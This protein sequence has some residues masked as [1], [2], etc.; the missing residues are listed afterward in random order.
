MM[1]RHLLR[2]ER[3]GSGYLFD[4]ETGKV[5]HVAPELLAAERMRGDVDFLPLRADA[6]RFA[7]SVPFCIWFELTLRCNLQ[8][9]HCS[10]DANTRADGRELGAAEVVPLLKQFADFGIFEVR[11]SG[12]EP[13][14]HREFPEIV[15]E[16]RRLGLFVST[17]TNGAWGES[18]R[19]R[20]ARLPVGLWIVSLDGRP[21]D[22]NALRPPGNTWAETVKTIRGL[23]EA[24]RRVRV[25]TVLCRTNHL[26]LREHVK[27]LVDL[28]VE[29]LTLVPVRPSGRAAD[30]ERFASLC[31]SSD[32]YQEVLGEVRALREE[33]AFEIAASYDLL[34]RGKMFN[35]PAHFAKRC[36]AGAEAA[37]VG[38]TGQLRACILLD[39]DKYVVGDLVRGS[40]D[41]TRLWADDASW[42]VF[43]DPASVPES[44]RDCRHLGV[45]C[46]GVCHV[47]RESALAPDL[48]FCPLKTR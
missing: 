19:R 29:A 21:R 16:A 46:F 9:V 8:C 28:G 14:C 26:G 30:P 15:E 24:G 17:S 1:E 48:P 27:T 31:L 41:L 33:Y 18:R 20:L 42:G 45:D 23:V 10:V 3:G 6:P 5:R 4:R 13:T 36:V 11:F 2:E 32:E 47:F 25:S 44:C 43:R 7:R 40:R 12:G 39:D 22:H 34:A 35:T 38:P 37:C